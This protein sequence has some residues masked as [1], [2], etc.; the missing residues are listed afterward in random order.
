[1]D[2]RTKAWAQQ[3][4]EQRVDNGASLYMDAVQSLKEEHRSI[5]TAM[6]KKAFL[7]PGVG[8][9]DDDKNDCGFGAPI[10]V[11]KTT[12]HRGIEEAFNVE[13][14]Q[15]FRH[16]YVYQITTG[17]IFGRFNSGSAL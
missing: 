11:A 4:M 13:A 12:D 7:L 17:V 8:N 5:Y 3:F 16:G 15:F 6:H 2:P 14:D 1:M 10:P 9:K